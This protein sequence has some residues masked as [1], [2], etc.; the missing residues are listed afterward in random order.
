MIASQ[1][2][3]RRSSNPERVLELKAKIND[4]EYLYGAIFRIAQVVSNEILGL[5]RGGI[6]NERY[7]FRKL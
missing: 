5:P 4:E 7:R 1:K 6:D 2:R 3:R